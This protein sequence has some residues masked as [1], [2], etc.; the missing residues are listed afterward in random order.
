MERMVERVKLCVGAQGPEQQ[1]E[2]T[3]QIIYKTHL[4]SGGQL[5]YTP[6]IERVVG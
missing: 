1:K 2:P 6:S 3:Q 5:L 4:A